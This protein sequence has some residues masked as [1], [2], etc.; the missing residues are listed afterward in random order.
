MD[1]KA[2]PAFAELLRRYRAV[3]GL[4]QEELAARS[5]LTP[6]AISLLERGE[7]Q[8]PQAYTFEKLA[9]VLEL[10]EADRARFAAAART[11]L[12]TEVPLHSGEHPVHAPRTNLPF[13][14]S[15]LIGRKREQGMVLALLERA[16]LVTLTGAGGVG[17]TRLALAVGGAAL[18]EYPQGVWLVELAALADPGL[19]A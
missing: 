4:T 13:A 19:V 8:R 12:S 7:R 15:S 6:Q 3:A 16:R 11:P 1:S 2:T 9:E 18:S 14:L 5:G 17:K 10:A